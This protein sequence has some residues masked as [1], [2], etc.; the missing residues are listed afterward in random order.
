MKKE[1]SVQSWLSRMAMPSLYL[2]LATMLIF[3][4]V[5]D[6]AKAREPKPA[7]P[8]IQESTRLR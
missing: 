3:V 7:T 2:L 8:F 6:R 1:E 4:F 5:V